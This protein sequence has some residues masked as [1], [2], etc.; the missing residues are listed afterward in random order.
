MRKFSPSLGSP[1]TSRFGFFQRTPIRSPLFSAMRSTA[2]GVSTVR[3]WACRYVDTAQQNKLA[4]AAPVHPSD[5]LRM[6]DA[7][8]DK[9]LAILFTIASL[10]S[11][12]LHDHN[13]GPR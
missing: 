1:I 12:L 10:D 11:C 7:K 6:K 9:P 8:G 13:R 3:V 5:A 4:R 2:S